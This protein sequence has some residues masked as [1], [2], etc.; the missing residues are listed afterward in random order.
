MLR[1]RDL[2]LIGSPQGPACDLSCRLE[3]STLVR[4]LEAH[5]VALGRGDAVVHRRELGAVLDV[6]AAV[7]AAEIRG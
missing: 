4:L 1:E 3:L 5:V 6:G 7:H 2:D